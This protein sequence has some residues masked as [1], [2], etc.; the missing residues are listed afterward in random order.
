MLSK[1]FV[2]LVVCWGV[3]S[4]PDGAPVDACVKDR[5]NQPNHGQ[6]RTQPLDTLPYRVVASSS[7]FG[8]NTPITGTLFKFKIRSF[9]R[10]FASGFR[11]VIEILYPAVSNFET[12]SSFSTKVY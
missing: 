7:T 9:L 1:L 10:G 8:P 4:F 3:E 6:H 12:I 5:P 11:F 2:V